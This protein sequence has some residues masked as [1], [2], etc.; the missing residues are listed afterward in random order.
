ML[1]AVKSHVSKVVN[2]RG[3]GDI[4]D[5]AIIR[6]FHGF[7]NSVIISAIIL[8]RKWLAPSM[9]VLSKALLSLSSG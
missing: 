8:K 2:F 1:W 3:A 7:E 5:I 4:V 9:K 6:V